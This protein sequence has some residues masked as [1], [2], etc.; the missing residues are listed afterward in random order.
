MST[1]NL[2]SAATGS[3]A[4]GANVALVRDP[5][6][7]V[8]KTLDQHK[9]TLTAIGVDAADVDKIAQGLLDSE[10]NA[11]DAALNAWDAEQDR[12]RAAREAAR[13]QAEQDELDQDDALREKLY[14]RKVPKAPAVLSAPLPKA[15]LFHIPSASL[16]KLASHLFTALSLYLPETMDA[17]RD[18]VRS[19]TSTSAVVPVQDEDGSVRWVPHAEALNPKKVVPDRDLT[20]PQI[21]KARNNLAKVMLQQA[22]SQVHVNR[23]TIFFD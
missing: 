2:A 14:R 23:W 9:A 21:L 13:A 4:G 1:V 16:E 19:S 3:G 15:D 20:L 8:L 6:A 7:D 18:T 22:V 10:R 17:Y 11:Y 5:R 12:L